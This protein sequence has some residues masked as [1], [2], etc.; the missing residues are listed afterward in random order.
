MSANK[1]FEESPQA[2]FEGAPLDLSGDIADWAAQIERE[3]EEAA[4][5][6]AK[7]ARKE[8]MREIRSTAGTHRVKA[9]RPA[10]EKLTPSGKKT[11]EKRTGGGTIIGGTNDPRARAAAGLNPVAGVDISLE[12]AQSLASSGV[13]ATVAALSALIETGDPNLREKAWVPHR[14]ER[15]QKS[16]GGIA[17]R[18]DTE[19][20]PSGDQPTAIKDLVEGL[21]PSSGPSGHLLPQG[22]KGGASASA[23]PSPLVGE[24]AERSEAGEGVAG[25]RTQ[26]L[27]G[28]TGSGKTFTMAKV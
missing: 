4:L 3:A 28:V 18:M 25:E 13:T 6:G 14:P 10:T 7:Q 5:R 12:D 11:T 20:K 2:P 19:F 1:G 26:V 23:L 27:L 15:P 21:I 22:E 8:E 16:E 24:G 9:G 17:F